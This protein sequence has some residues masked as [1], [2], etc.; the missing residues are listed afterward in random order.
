MRRQT[1]AILHQQAKIVMRPIRN[2]NLQEDED[3]SIKMGGKQPKK[4]N[5]DVN[6]SLPLPFL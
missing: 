4:K 2:K 5:P 1:E 3:Q 6:H